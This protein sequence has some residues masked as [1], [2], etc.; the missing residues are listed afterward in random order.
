MNT[1]LL[2]SQIVL[3]GHSFSQVSH[4]LEVSRSSFYRKMY[5]ENEFTRKEMLKLKHLLDLPNDVMMDI[6]FNE[7]VS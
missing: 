6:F 3:K 4:Y 2:K 1:N 7:K 5:G